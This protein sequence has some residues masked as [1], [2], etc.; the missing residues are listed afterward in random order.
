MTLH[1]RLAAEPGAGLAVARFT[2]LGE[3][4]VTSARAQP[5]AEAGFP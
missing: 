4:K 3:L 5:R 2:C 1:A